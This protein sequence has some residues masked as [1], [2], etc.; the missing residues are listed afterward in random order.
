MNSICSFPDKLKEQMRPE[1]VSRIERSLV[2]E[3][4]VKE[5]NIQT[6]EDEIKAEVEKMAASYGLKAEKM[7]EQMSEED[8]ESIRRD[9][10]LQKA[11]SLIV[12]HSVEV[13]EIEE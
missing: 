5:Q 8:K 12:E 13:E 4:I 11:A 10:A 3:Q 7:M 6:T 1:A 9:Y 2:L